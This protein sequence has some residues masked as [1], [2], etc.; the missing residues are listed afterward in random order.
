MMSDIR[1]ERDFAVT[2]ARLFKAL[3][4][5]ALLMQ[6]WGHDGMQIPDERLDFSRL[7]PWHAVMISDEGNRF[8]M[9]GQVT[10]VDPP[11]SI[12]FTWGWHD[13]D[14]QRGPES[15]VMFT[16]EKTSKGARLT[17][18]HRALPNDDVARQHEKGWGGPLNRL[19][20]L[21]AD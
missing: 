21:L 10:H 14:D 3:S 6:W 8:K 4:T 16:V 11:H 18:D 17:I 2:P 7:G 20:R 9:S 15:H 1:L 19:E 13:P 5:H 12:G